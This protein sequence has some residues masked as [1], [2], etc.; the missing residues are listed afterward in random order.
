M[1]GLGFSE[2]IVALIVA[3]L[4][5]GPKRLPEVARSLGKSMGELRRAL[6]DIKQ[7]VAD[8]QLDAPPLTPSEA[9]QHCESKKVAA[10][11][12]KEAQ[13][14]NIQNDTQKETSE[15]KQPSSPDPTDEL[16]NT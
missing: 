15:T 1:F 3:L 6:D 4:V 9:N 13:T 11:E 2:I 7:D 14:T 5:F 8:I 12:E 16:P 10:I